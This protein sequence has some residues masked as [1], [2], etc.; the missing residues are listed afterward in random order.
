[1]IDYWR[2]ADL[3]SPEALAAPVTVIGAGG[4]GSPVA[5]ALAKMG[6]QNLT[7]YDPDVV[8]PHNLPNQFYRPRD[9]GRP[10]VAALADVIAEF[11]GAEVRAVQESVAGQPLSGV[12]ISGVDSMASRERIWRESIRY[13]PGV[14]VYIDAR[15]GAQVCRVLTVRPVDPDDVRWYE[16]TLFADDG[17]NEEPCTA[18][19]IIYTTLGLASLVANQVKR[20]AM[21]EAFERDLLI[22]FATLTVLRGREL[23]GDGE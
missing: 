4:I 12:V 18:R 8:E 3:I 13:R 10:K 9:V 1:V 7:L 11:T 6:C 15:M 14:S 19:A 20:H 22:D 21:S 23:H 5:L 2:Q 17:A 16:S